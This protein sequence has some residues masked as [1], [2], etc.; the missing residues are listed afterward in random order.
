M[1]DSN[2]IQPLLSCA[3]ESSDLQLP[4][5]SSGKVRDSY[6]LEGGLRLIVTTDRLSAFDRVLAALPYKGQVLNQLSAWWFEHTRET[7]ANHMVSVPDPNAMLCRSAQP[8]P[9]EVV[10]RGYITGVT[11]TALWYLYSQG[12]AR[13]LRLPLPR[14][15][16]QERSAPH[17][18][19]YP[20]HQGRADR[21][22]RAPDLRR[23]S[24]PGLPG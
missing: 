3:F 15:A 22:R 6:P 10:V 12:R 16:A 20:H 21:A 14:R 18:D 19:H 1:L 5:K 4:G 2:K 9:V 7:I 11:H 24:R 8:L 13:H 17:G 23:S